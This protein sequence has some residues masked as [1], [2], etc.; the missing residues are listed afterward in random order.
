M[1]V[2]RLFRWVMVKVKRDTQI[3]PAESFDLIG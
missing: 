1:A 3:H 2:R